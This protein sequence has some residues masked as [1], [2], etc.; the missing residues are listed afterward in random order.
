MR[1]TIAIPTYNNVGTIMKTIESCLD[2]DFEKKNYEII[3]V[4]NAST[5]GT[6]ELL[7]SLKDRV[8]IY[9]N[10][11]TF[12]MYKNHNICLEKAKGEYIIFCHADDMLLENALS[13]YE[14]TLKKRK[15]PKKCVIW[16]R[17]MFRDYY[18]HLKR[19]DYNLNEILSGITMLN[20]FQ[21]GLTPSGTCYSRESFMKDGGFIEVNHFL[22]PSDLV[23]IWK[24]VICYYEFEMSGKI[25][26]KRT[27][28]STATGSVYNN[29]TI[30][31]SLEDAFSSLFINLNKANQKLI[32]SHVVNSNFNNRAIL[33][34]LFRI[35]KISPKKYLFKK[36]KISLQSKA[37]RV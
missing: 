5:D 9:R 25:F 4:D 23:T 20:V 8:T 17:S 15:Y 3:V 32:V 29:R 19:E 21:G 2:Q 6:S 33:K 16:G 22:A 35:K 37:N 30:Q 10:E 14:L 31:H 1:F 36:I 26:F 11:I 34:A 27:S 24:L 13:N 12:S 28:A 18:L 7:E